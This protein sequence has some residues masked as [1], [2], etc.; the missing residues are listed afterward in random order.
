MVDFKCSHTT[1]CQTN[2]IS[3]ATKESLPSVESMYTFSDQTSANISN[4]CQIYIVPGVGWAIST[5]EEHLDTMQGHYKPYG[6]Q[7]AF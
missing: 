4:E 3:Q 5:V 7:W 1:L 2:G 6:N